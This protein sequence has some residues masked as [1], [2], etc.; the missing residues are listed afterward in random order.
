MKAKSGSYLLICKRS[1]E[2]L[3]KFAFQL[4]KINRHG[5]FTQTIYLP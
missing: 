4:Y 2:I 3:V 5:A 1:I